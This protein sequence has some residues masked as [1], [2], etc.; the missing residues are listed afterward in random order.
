MSNN[1]EVE[2]LVEQ[3]KD[4]QLRQTAVLQRLE[5]LTESPRGS[6]APAAPA[7][8][9][10]PRPDFIIGDRVRITNPRPFQ[11][12]VGIVTKISPSR[13]FIRTKNGAV[14]QRAPSNVVAAP[15]RHAD[16]E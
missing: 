9:T 3:L 16:H 15:G 5:R 14:I 4:L 13:I 10:E 6:N 11:Q 12:A 2:E 7:T 8:N 1:K